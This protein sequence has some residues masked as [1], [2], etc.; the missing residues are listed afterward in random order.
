[1]RVL[2]RQWPTAGVLLGRGLPETKSTIDGTPNLV[3]LRFSRIPP[4]KFEQPLD[5]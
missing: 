3:T 4:A 2:E 5:S 1:V